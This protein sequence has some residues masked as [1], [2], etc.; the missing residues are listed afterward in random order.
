MTL[1]IGNK[2]V[3]TNGR[4]MNPKIN[5]AATIDIAEDGDTESTYISFAQEDIIRYERDKDY[6]EVG[7]TEFT[8]SIAKDFKNTLDREVDFRFWNS[9]YSSTNRGTGKSRGQGVVRKPV[10][11]HFGDEQDGRRDIGAGKTNSDI[12][13]SLKKF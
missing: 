10:N 5:T 8:Q 7:L 11:Y 1:P 13:Y 12:R 2:I 4:Y 3:Y 6:K 9:E